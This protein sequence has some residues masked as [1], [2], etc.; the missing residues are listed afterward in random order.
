MRSQSLFT[1]LVFCLVSTFFCSAQDDEKGIFSSIRL[2]HRINEHGDEF[3]SMDMSPDRSRIAVGTEKGDVYV[4]NVAAS[5]LDHEFHEGHPVHQV[6]FV[7]DGHIVI[8]GGDHTG[9]HNCL[10][11]R[12]DVAN[13]K[14]EEWSGAGSESLIYLSFDHE[15]G[16]I[17]TANPLGPITAWDVR[18]ASKVASWNTDKPIASL[19]LAGD[20]LFVARLN[21]SIQELSTNDDERLSGDIAKY[22]V[23]SPTAKPNVFLASKDGLAGKLTI[24]PDKKILSADVVDGGQEALEFY[25]VSNGA[26]LGGIE[27]PPE[28]NLRWVGDRRALISDNEEPIRF[29]TLAKDKGIKSEEIT[30]GGGFH[31]NGNPTGVSGVAVSSDEKRVWITYE[32]LGSLVE[33]DL[34]NKTSKGLIYISPF[35]YAMDVRESGSNG[36]LATAGDDKYVRVRDLSDLHMV[37]EIATQYTPQGVAL[38][39]DGKTVMYSASSDAIPTD[40]ISVDIQTGNSQKLMT[41]PAPFARVRK[42]GDGFLYEV[43]TVQPPSTADTDK[44]PKVTTTK[45]VQA[46]ADGM[47]VREY[48][49]PRGIDQWATSHNAG[50]MVISD[51]DHKLSV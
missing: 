28:L 15:T 17:V 5:K 11:G 37:R 40:V 43:G 32:K 38:M 9:V 44:M 23:S 24:S 31:G 3:M 48:S 45:L 49:R 1:A 22:A 10:F 36:Y 21:Q 14:F 19:V 47:S 42:G 34:T 6:V 33:F 26:V 30:K 50:W 29:V 8:A 16:T 20:S 25:D 41:L 7:D 2:N 27:Q 4:W 12:L 46:T 39:P 35:P 13:G 51:N 18:K